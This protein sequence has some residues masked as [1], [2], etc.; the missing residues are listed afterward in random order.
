MVANYWL[1]FEAE[2][3]Q[4][5]IQGKESKIFSNGC[6]S[7]TKVIFVIF[8]EISSW[9]ESFIRMAGA[10]WRIV[11]RI[12]VLLWLLHWLA[13]FLEKNKFL[14]LLIIIF[15]TFK[16]SFTSERHFANNFP[17]S[18]NQQ[19]LLDLRAFAHQCFELLLAEIRTASPWQSSD[20][21]WAFLVA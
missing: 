6:Y 1:K 18:G 11:G 21:L 17:N 2:V 4:V 7:Q 14:Q 8:V 19:I 10:L 20:C 9:Q 12:K 13:C 3:V 16:F 5:F 15:S